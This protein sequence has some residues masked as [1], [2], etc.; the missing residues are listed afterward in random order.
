MAP[1]GVFKGDASEQDRHD[2][3][4]VTSAIGLTFEETLAPSRVGESYRSGF[5][6]HST[7]DDKQELR[8]LARHFRTT[9]AGLIRVCYKIGVAVFREETFGAIDE[10]AE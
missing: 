2:F 3:Y 4:Q 8:E 1:R 5:S 6:F 10:K 9:E 7:L